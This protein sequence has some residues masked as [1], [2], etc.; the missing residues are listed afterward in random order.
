VTHPLATVPCPHCRTP[1]IGA[2]L[3]TALHPQ[4]LWCA[5]DGARVPQEAEPVCEDCDGDETFECNTCRPVRCEVGLTSASVW[6]TC[7]KGAY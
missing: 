3:A 7:W 1:L 5:W 6:L 2:D 4:P